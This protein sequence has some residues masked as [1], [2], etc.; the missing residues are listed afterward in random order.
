MW[1]AAGVA[2]L[3]VVGF[4]F[5]TDLAAGCF[6]FLLSVG[7]WMPFLVT[8]V[9]AM[10]VV[11]LTRR[12]A[13]G[14]AGSGIPQ[15]MA[16]MS[17]AV[18]MT[19]VRHFVSVWL[20]LAKALLGS[21]AL[22]VGFSAGREGPSVQ[23][24]AGVMLG[25][26]RWFSG[27][28]YVTAQDLMLVG[29]AA[30]IA[31]AF[32]APLAGV[33]FAIEE[34]SRRFEQ[35]SSGLIVSAIIFA[36][37]VS[38]AILGNFTYFGRINITALPGQLFLPAVVCVILA[39]LL[40]GLFS[41]LLI[42]SSRGTNDRISAFRNRHPIRFAGLCGLGLAALGL[43]SHGAAY[44]SGYQY[45]HDVLNGSAPLPFLYVGVKFFATWLT[46]WSGVPGGIFAPSLA[47]GA[48]LGNDVALLM[49]A[50]P[51]PLI[52]LGMVGFLAAATQAPI[53]SFIIVMEM[54]DG[55]ALVLSLMATAL[56]A[57]LISKLIS[58]PLYHSLCQL[59]LMRMQKE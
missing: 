18:A 39:G 52:A 58:P 30:G 55:H 40:G 42:L 59:Q 48:G 9:G 53:T 13:P 34:L 54:I 24:A 14:A 38:V 44:G 6:H 1:T 47:V 26:R 35:R 7:A 33:M 31:A 28:S 50:T 16:G 11:W 2:G 29:G 4:T 41:R 12:F 32:N 10:L 37:L 51:V 5:L 43:V 21:L 57:S 27:R 49:H 19:S 23:I 8:P 15:V 36:G 17:D 3:C 20:S 45:T 56:V 46:Y 22:A 25:F